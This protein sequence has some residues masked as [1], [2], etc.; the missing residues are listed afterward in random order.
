MA[1]CEKVAEA[2]R[3]EVS[4]ILHDK[5]KDPRLGFVTITRVEVAADLR[6]AK[7][8]FSVL[9]ARDDYE[10]TKKALDSALGFIRKLVSERINLKFAPEILFKE[11]H[12]SEYSV[13]IQQVLDEIKEEE[14]ARALSLKKTVRKRGRK[15]SEPR[16][17]R[18]LHQKE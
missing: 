3:Q 1:R 14:A 17:S 13:R 6:S 18:R 7:I 12:S 9:G 15:Q 16:K 8:F 5:L 10:K 2:I 4:I 11:D